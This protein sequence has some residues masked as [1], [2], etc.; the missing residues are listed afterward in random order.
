MRYYPEMRDLIGTLQ[1]NGGELDLTNDTVT[2][3]NALKAI[4][5]GILELTGTTVT[6][7]GGVDIILNDDGQVATLLIMGDEGRPGEGR[8]VSDDDAAVALDPRQAE[9][10]DGRPR[11]RTR[12]GRSRWRAPEWIW[13]RRWWGF[14]PRTA[15][16]RR[17]MVRVFTARDCSRA[18]CISG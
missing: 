14:Q 6:N 13:R 16:N 1:A 12:P 18:V 17:T 9:A 11:W 7:T 2:N 4:N 10:R 5:N 15:L 3:T 8:V